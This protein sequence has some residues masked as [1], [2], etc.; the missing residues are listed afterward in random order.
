[1]LS[2]AAQ[3]EIE[4]VAPEFL[5]IG[6]DPVL[7]GLECLHHAKTKAKANGKGNLHE[8]PSSLFSKALPD[9]AGQRQDRC[10]HS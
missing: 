1:M 4:S 3:A 9:A 6:I 7:A 8:I 10:R 2:R 5:Q